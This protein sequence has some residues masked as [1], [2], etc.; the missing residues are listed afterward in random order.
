MWSDFC[1]ATPR[2]GKATCKTAALCQN[3][4]NEHDLGDTACLCGCIQDMAPDAAVLLWAN[5]TCAGTSCPSECVVHGSNASCLKCYGVH[6]FMEQ[7][8]CLAN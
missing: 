1:G 8:H 5:D 7:A 3:A 2:T 4:C 6:C